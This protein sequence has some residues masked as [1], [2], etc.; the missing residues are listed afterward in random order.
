MK[1]LFSVLFLSLLVQFS[2]MKNTLAQS[3]FTFKE[4]A[5]AYGKENYNSLITAVDGGEI[6]EET[7]E[8]FMKETYKMKSK[9][10]EK[11]VLIVH[12]VLFPEI[13]ANKRGDIYFFF[14]KEDNNKDKIFEMS[15]AFA[16]G[17]DIVVNTKDYPEEI[18]KMQEIFRKY[19]VYHHQ[20]YFGN[21]IKDLEKIIKEHN[22]NIEKN[23]NKMKGLQKDNENLTKKMGKAKDAD[24]VKLEQERINNESEIKRLADSDDLL[25]KQIQAVNVDIDNIKSKIGNL[26]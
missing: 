3:V 22:R 16:F 14:E 21:Q 5:H 24:K 15:M 7:F 4:G 11:G 25:N 13:S 6:A 2:A 9:R 20:K 12:K 19:L 1:K 23:K 8:D 26:K 17:Y 10:D 18:K